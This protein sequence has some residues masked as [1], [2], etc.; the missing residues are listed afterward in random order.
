MS[1]RVKRKF[2]LLMAVALALSAPFARATEE[3]E[4]TL[5]DKFKKL[6]SRPTSTPKHRKKKKPSPSPAESKSPSSVETPVSSTS[7]PEP[8]ATPAGPTSETPAPTAEMKSP[9]PVER[10]P[11]Q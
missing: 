2:I 5:G 8:N 3:K 9:T 7:P 11:T 10:A 1:S 6:F 4:E